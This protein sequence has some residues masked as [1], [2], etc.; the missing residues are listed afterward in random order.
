MVVTATGKALGIGISGGGNAFAIGKRAAFANLR[1]TLRLAMQEAGV[2]PGSLRNI[3]VGT[4]SVTSDGSNAA[5][6]E[7]EL[8]S[9]LRNQRVRVVGDARIA[10]TGALA[11]EPG[12]VAVAGT[13]SIVLGQSSRG[14]F[15]R[16]GGWGPLAGDEGSAQWLGRRALQEAAHC[17]DQNTRRTALLSSICSHYRLRNFD[18]VLDIIYDHPMTSAELGALAPLVTEA[19]G[20]GDRAARELIREGAGAL[21]LQTATAARRLR[22]K[23]PLISHQGS[24]FSV[25]HVFRAAFS[26]ELHRLLP[27]SR[28]IK[29]RLTPIGGAFLLALADAQLRVSPA[30]IHNFQESGNG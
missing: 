16:V 19:A 15:V 26:E 22:L 20:K 5:P 7:A 17:A 23:A 2:K 25:C 30:I 21:A 9:F 6:I 13:G 11:G 29:P 1:R 27:G 8:R 24:M 4:A 14:S 10:L 12:V 28:V 3:V 18:E